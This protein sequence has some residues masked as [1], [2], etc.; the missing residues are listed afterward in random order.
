MADET[1]RKQASAAVVDVRPLSLDEIFGADPEPEFVPP[2]LRAQRTAPVAPQRPARTLPVPSLAGLAPFWVLAGRG[3]TGKTVMARYLAGELEQRG[4]GRFVLAALDPGNR[5]LAEFVPTVHQPPGTG[6]RETALFLRDFLPRVM[7][8]KAPVIA[9]VGAGNTAWEATI[10]A[11]PTLPRDLEDAGVGLINAY[12]F[13]ASPDDP[14]ILEQH[15]GAGYTPRATLLVLNEHN[16]GS[17]ADFDR[18]RAHPGY[19][20]ALARGAVEIILPVLETRVAQ[21]IEARRYHFFQARD[22]IVPPE[23][24]NPPLQLSAIE[25]VM[26]REFIDGVAKELAPLEAAGWLPWG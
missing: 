25:R 11:R 26:V 7:K 16:V 9:D 15:A 17:A 24:P 18:I 13:G 19:K 12:F 4:V 6:E 2:V 8:A 5:L 10:R 3:N 1:R 23:N 21:L 14:A 22:G 20:A